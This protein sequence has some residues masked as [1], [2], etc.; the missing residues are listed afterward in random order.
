[1]GGAGTLHCNVCGYEEKIISFLHGFDDG[2][3][4]WHECGYQCQDCGKIIS[5]ERNLSLKKIP[6]CDCGGE[7]SREEPLFC[8]VCKSFSLEYKMRIIT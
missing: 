7:M 8:P 3:D 2:P 4:S 6:T 1:M 5:I